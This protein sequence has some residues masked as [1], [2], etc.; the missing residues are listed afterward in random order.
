MNKP[1]RVVLLAAWG[2]FW[3]GTTLFFNCVS[4]ANDEGKYIKPYT[5]LPLDYTEEVEY[6]PGLNPDES[7]VDYL[8]SIGSGPL[9]PGS[10][11]GYFDPTGVEDGLVIPDPSDH[12]LWR[13][14]KMVYE[15]KYSDPYR[16]TYEQNVKLMLDLKDYLPTGG[17]A[18]IHGSPTTKEL[19]ALRMLTGSYATIY[20]PLYRPE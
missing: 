20:Y 7:V 15:I 18:L 5:L 1:G 6:P 16:G 14:R 10:R 11:N 4:W 3:F 13:I 19:H 8:K 2:A 12:N 17:S 9:N